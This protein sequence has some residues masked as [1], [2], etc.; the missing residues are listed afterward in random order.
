M[1]SLGNR[2]VDHPGAGKN[3]P[4]CES[5][6]AQ[7]GVESNASA[8]VIYHAYYNQG[9]LSSEINKLM[10]LQNI[11]PVYRRAVGV[12]RTAISGGADVIQKIEKGVLQSW[13][14]HR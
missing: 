10:G 14:V 8:Y 13:D 1:L 9:R 12:R 6:S 7:N 4:R 2:G 5:K 3:S 11:Y